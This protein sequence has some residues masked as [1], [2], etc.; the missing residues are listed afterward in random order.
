[1][2]KTKRYPVKHTNALW[3]I[4]DTVSFWKV[5]K[6]FVVIQ[7]ARYTPFL[8]VK[9]WLYR[10]LLSMEVGKHTAFALM[11]MPDIMFP[12]K[13]KV[14]DN[15]VIGY[16][17]TILAHEYLIKEYR[18]GEV[19]TNSSPPVMPAARF[20][21]T[22]PS[23]TTV[24]PV[25]YSHAWSP[26]PS[27]TAS[28]PDLRTANRSPARPATNSSPPVAPYSTVF[29]ASHGS[30]ASSGRGGD[31]DTAAA[32]PLADVVVRPPRS[33]GAR[34]RPRGT[35]RTTGP[36]RRGSARGGAGRRRRAERLADRA[37]QPRADGPVDVRD[38]QVDL[39]RA[40]VA[41]R[42]PAPRRTAGRRR[43]DVGRAATSMATDRRSPRGRRSSGET[44]RRSAGTSI[45]RGR[46][47]SARP[48]TSSSVR[49]PR[50][51]S[52]PRTSSAT[53]VMNAATISGVPANFARSSGRWVAIPTGHVSRWH[54]RTMRQPSASS[55]AVPN[56]YSSAPSSAATI[57]SLP[58]FRP[59]ST[60]RRTRDA[61]RSPPSARCASTRPSSH[62][63]PAFLID[64]SGEAPVPPSARRC[65]P[66]R[67][68][69]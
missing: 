42:R 66:R 28:A 21:T 49:N 27:T 44:S 12:E 3:Q 59:P 43:G 35:R 60:R 7:V 51:A 41:D 8:P 37:A 11:V 54:V 25:M 29:P 6:N 18:I 26:T 30:P 31:H 16:N 47:R 10:E 23:T 17:T 39:D 65:A 20:L 5:M 53:A 1:M 24:P 9:N 40:A 57:T 69:P 32:H 33:A 61:G 56:E 50:H 22:G 63:S 14:G 58:V 67:R 13:I 46:S 4:Y 52:R 34:H 62:G 48:I 19:P 64:D 36:P 15:S 68:A 38:R 2:R 45:S 55:A